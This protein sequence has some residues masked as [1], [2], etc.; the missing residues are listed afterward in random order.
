MDDLTDTLIHA[1][2]GQWI[3]TLPSGRMIVY[4]DE[5]FRTLYVKA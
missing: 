2:V 1:N 4:T 5:E 3:V